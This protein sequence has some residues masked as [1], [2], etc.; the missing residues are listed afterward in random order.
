MVVVGAVAPIWLAAPLIAVGGIGYAACD[1]VG[2]TI[3]QRVTPDR[4][5]ARVLGALEGS[6]SPVS[7]S[8]RSS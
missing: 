3:L 1:V 7:R 8:G 6:T 5:L 4:M 2:R